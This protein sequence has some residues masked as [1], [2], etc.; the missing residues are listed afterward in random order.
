[1]C[2]AP[3]RAF[4]KCTKLHSGY[5]S[6]DKCI[7]PGAYYKN[8]IVFMS[9]TA[10]KRTNESFRKQLDDNHHHGSSPFLDLPIDLIKSFP[11]DYM[12]NI[13]L[14]VMRLL[15]RLWIAG[16]LKFKLTNNQMQII[17]QRLINLQ[18]FIPL[19]FNRKPRSLNE[20]VYWKATE[21]RTFLIYIGPLVLKN[22]LPRAIYENFLLL[23]VGISI[24]I[25]KNHINNFGIPFAKNCLL[26]FINHCKN[27]LYGLEFVVYN[28]HL[29]T[30]ICD[31]VEIYGSLDEYSSFPFESY[32]GHLKK[33]IRSPTNPLQQIHRRLHE[34][35]SSLLKFKE[36][37]LKNPDRAKYN[38]DME[39][40]NGPLVNIQ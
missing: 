20:L 15:L 38:V 7:E 14:G 16:S 5:S 30:H 12:H 31:D 37:N 28:V 22:I 21:Y 27:E 8:K 32:L 19:E 35:N 4:L 3:A 29:L 33:L 40:K 24:L 11:I 10:P 6:C 17:S 23:H 34:I 25:S 1:V 18:K 9:E 39:Y 2:D 36:H 26:T 13:C